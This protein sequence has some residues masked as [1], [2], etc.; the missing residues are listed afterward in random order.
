MSSLLSRYWLLVPLI[1]VAI[2]VR[3]W[4]ETPE[5]L[6]SEEPL[7]IQQLR[8]DYY[9]EDFTT[10]RFD[11]AGTLEYLLS[12]DTLSHFPED[13]RAEIRAPAME[14]HRP[15]A[16]WDG[17]AD[18]G[19]FV[20]APDVVTLTGDVVLEREPTSPTSSGASARGSL[21]VRADDL[22]VAVATNEISTAGPVE[23]VAPGW[24]LR[25]VGLQS[26]IDEGKLE[27]LSEVHG[28][29]EVATP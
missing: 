14:L 18:A 22:S 10:R 23:V 17:R 27:L 4:V 16:R 7:A 24:R 1:L 19:T 29:Y 21:V 8:A 26:S 20:R 12:G 15:D 11:E 6:A 5:T 9:L 13:D 2:V 3:N 25:A 28:R